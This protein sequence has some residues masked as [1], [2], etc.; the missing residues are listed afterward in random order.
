[1]K[2]KNLLLLVLLVSL[3]VNSQ[4]LWEKISTVDYQDLEKEV[5]HKKNFPQKYKLL[6]LDLSALNSSYKARSKSANNV[7]EL[8]DADGKLRRFQLT[9]TS[10]FES[11]LQNKY[12]N[13]KS[14]TAKGIDDPTATAKLSLG[15]DGFHG[16]I[17]AGGKST[18]YIDPYSKDNQDYIVYQRKDL[19]ANERNF[20]CK[21]GGHTKSSAKAFGYKRKV[22]DGKLRTFRLA[23]VCS[24][25]YAQF[26]LT[27]QNISNSAS[28][29]TKKAAVLSAEPVEEECNFGK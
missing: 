28:D 4:N 9:E 7:I 24:G 14:Y 10:N 19:P 21:V 5:Y 29:A 8:P 16:T 12:P 22:N 1:M 6:T 2:A 11:E 18:V 17:Y 3:Q 13:I 15:T 25:E 23:I 20:H 27:R 26:H